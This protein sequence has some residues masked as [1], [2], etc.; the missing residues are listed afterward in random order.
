M[1]LLL[2]LAVLACVPTLLAQQ[3]LIA[4]VKL[5]WTAL[6]DLPNE[7]GVAGPFVGVHNGALVVAGGANFNRPVWDNPK[8]WL[9]DVWIATSKINIE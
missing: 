8:T 3:A 5:E 6:P 1:L 2:A 4:M 9:D 7:L